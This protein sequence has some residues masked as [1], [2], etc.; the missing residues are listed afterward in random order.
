MKKQIVISFESAEQFTGRQIVDAITDIQAVFEA[1][2]VK[3]E[4][5][6]TT[7]G[8]DGVHRI[9]GRVEVEVTL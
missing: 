1:L 7:Y 9:R 8:N 5:D 4:P 3:E 6:I 2:G